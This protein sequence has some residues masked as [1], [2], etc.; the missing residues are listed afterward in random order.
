MLEI[1][2][3]LRQQHIWEAAVGTECTEG[4]MGPNGGRD[5][6]EEVYLSP[7]AGTCV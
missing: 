5:G 2:L 7:P 4:C 6:G 1:I 3:S